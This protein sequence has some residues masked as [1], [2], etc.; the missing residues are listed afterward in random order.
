MK[1]PIDTFLRFTRGFVKR[2][3]ADKA[4]QVS[5]AYNQD[6]DPDWQPV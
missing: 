6:P 2:H 1:L 3:R 4:P 5:P